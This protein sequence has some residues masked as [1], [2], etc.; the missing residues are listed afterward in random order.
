MTLKEDNVINYNANLYPL[1]RSDSAKKCFLTKLMRTIR[2]KPK[3]D[4]IQKPLL[5]SVIV[6][7]I[8]DFWGN[9]AVIEILI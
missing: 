2:Q 9:K 8:E 7:A 4:G 3:T 5:D 6:F 1:M